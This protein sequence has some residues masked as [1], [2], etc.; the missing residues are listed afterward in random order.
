MGDS[1]GDVL[2]RVPEVHE[3]AGDVDLAGA[4]DLA[5]AAAAADP[6]MDCALSDAA[7]VRAR[8][9]SKG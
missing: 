3:A 8:L 1:L 2:E 9:S 4:F 7:R 5:P 6:W